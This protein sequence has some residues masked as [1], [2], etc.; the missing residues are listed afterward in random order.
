[1]LCSLYYLGDKYN[2]GILKNEALETIREE[3]VSPESVLDVAALADKFSIHDKLAEAL[4]EAAARSLSKTFDG[5]EVL[6]KVGDFFSEL[7]T[8]AAP[9][10]CKSLVRIMAKVRR[11]KKGTCVRAWC[12]FNDC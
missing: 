2:I 6:D 8:A 3:V 11:K 7:D 10:S 5:G 9:A 1:M 12:E 4:S